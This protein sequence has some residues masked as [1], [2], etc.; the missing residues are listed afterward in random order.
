MGWSFHSWLRGGWSRCSKGPCYPLTAAETQSQ[1]TPANF[2][3]VPGDL[4]RYGAALDGSTDDTWP[5]R[6]ALAQAQQPNGAPVYLPRTTGGCRIAASSSLPPITNQITIYGDDLNRSDFLLSND[7]TLFIFKDQGAYY[8]SLRR[9]AIIGRG[10]GATQ[11]AVVFNN[12]AYTIIDSCLIRNCG[13]GVQYQ[14]GSGASFLNTIRD[15]QIVNN[16]TVCI[17]CQA[18]TN[19][20]SLFNVTFGGGPAQKGIHIV[21]SNTLS[22]FGFDCEG[23]SVC[24]IDIDATMSGTGGHFICG[25][26]L[27]GNT[28]SLG[29]IRLGGSNLYPVIGVSIRGLTLSSGAGDLAFLNAVNCIGVSVSDCFYGSGYSGAG[30]IDGWLLLGT[31]ARGVTVNN[32]S[33]TTASVESSIQTFGTIAWSHSPISGVATT[34]VSGGTIST[35]GLT[36]Q[37]VAPNTV[38]TG[39][40]L[41]AGY[42]PGQQFALINEAQQSSITFAAPSVSNVADR[43]ADVIAGLTARSFVWNS[44]TARWYRQV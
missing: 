20:L 40:I 14:T 25:G 35:S 16:Q 10:S 22:I 43:T 32:F 8:S 44:V 21:D 42:R 9:I 29:D 17:D 1:I 37:R 6:Q 2:G 39:V 15:S 41:Q 19:V 18:G 33:N 30:L 7:I 5:L 31:N 36:V 12:C 38:V 27:E 24:A 23:V 26:D 13:I 34:L 4:R 3:Y 28:C 11:P